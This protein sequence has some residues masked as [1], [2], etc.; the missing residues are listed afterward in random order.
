MYI[1]KP[2]QR[3]LRAYEPFHTLSELSDA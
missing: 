3:I 2:M 1:W